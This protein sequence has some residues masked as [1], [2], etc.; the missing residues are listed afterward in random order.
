MGKPHHCVICRQGH[1][2]LSPDGFSLIV[3]NCIRGNDAVGRR[4]CLHHLELYSTHASPDQED[5][6][7]AQRK[8]G[9]V[10]WAK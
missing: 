10:S 2:H 8:E 1:T 6:T 5:V 4:V 9:K 7:Y 3:D